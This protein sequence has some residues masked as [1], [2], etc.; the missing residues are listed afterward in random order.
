MISIFT[1]IST[2][3]RSFLCVNMH[4]LFFFSNPHTASPNLP[5]NLSEYQDSCP[6]NIPHP[7]VYFVQPYSV[8]IFDFSCPAEINLLTFCAHNRLDST[9]KQ[10]PTPAGYLTGR[11]RGRS[12]CANVRVRTY[13]RVRTLIT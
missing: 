8:H 4:V 13:V 7:L 3:F 10:A 12:T 6:S 5:T 11:P 2:D 9:V 1:Y